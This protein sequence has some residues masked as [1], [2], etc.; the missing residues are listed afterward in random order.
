MHIFHL[1]DIGKLRG[2]NSGQSAAF[3]TPGNYF[4]TFQRGGFGL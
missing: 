3:W 2:S 4:A 1:F